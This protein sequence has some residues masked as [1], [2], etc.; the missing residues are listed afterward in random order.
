M[1][2]E[3]ESDRIVGGK[4]AQD[5]TAPYQALILMKNKTLSYDGAYKWKQGKL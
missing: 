2:P 1:I 3:A 5:Y 4:F